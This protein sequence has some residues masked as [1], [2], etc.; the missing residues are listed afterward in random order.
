MDEKSGLIVLVQRTSTAVIVYVL[1]P[2]HKM[3][4]V[5]DPVFSW[6]KVGKPAPESPS[7]LSLGFFKV[8]TNL[9]S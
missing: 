5:F 8:S 1:F 4:V 3:G 7:Q 2:Q 9:F 6:L